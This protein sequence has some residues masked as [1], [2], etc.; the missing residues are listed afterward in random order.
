MQALRGKRGEL[1]AEIQDLE[2][3]AKER[4]ARVAHIDEVIRLF[5]PPKIGVRK[6]YGRQGYFKLGDL[7]RLVTD[8]LRER[9]VSS[10][11]SQLR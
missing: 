2:R 8:H 1:L 6:R 5:D 3:R 11:A 4:R 7:S 10:T 9:K